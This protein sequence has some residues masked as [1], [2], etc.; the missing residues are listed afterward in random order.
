[1]CHRLYHN[2]CSCCANF[3]FYLIVGQFFTALCL[4]HRVV[5]RLVIGPGVLAG[6]ITEWLVFGQVFGVLMSLIALCGC[7]GSIFQ[8]KR[9]LQI[10]TCESRV[11]TT[12]VSW[13]SLVKCLHGDL[14]NYGY[15]PPLFWH[16]G[17]T[18]L[19]PPN[20]SMRTARM[21]TGQ[22]M[23]VSRAWSV[24]SQR[25]T[26]EHRRHSIGRRTGLTRRSISPAVALSALTQSK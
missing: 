22:V 15:Y 19:R 18:E 24:S 11:R 20:H 12:I 1:M 10:M 17:S 9:L 26:G 6:S 14:R 25:N 21:P 23:T 7:C 5:Q 16:R 8:L 4:S 2:A 13:P 3:G